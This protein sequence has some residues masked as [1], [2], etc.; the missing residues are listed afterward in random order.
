[1]EQKHFKKFIIFNFIEIQIWIFS[2]FYFS[3]VKY[4]NKLC[5]DANDCAINVP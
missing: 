3:V 2:F 1:M 5:Q 4:K